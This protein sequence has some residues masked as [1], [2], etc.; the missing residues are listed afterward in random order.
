MAPQ[1]QTVKRK[2]LVLGGIEAVLYERFADHADI[3]HVPR[4]K[5]FRNADIATVDGVIMLTAQLSHTVVRKVKKTA[6]KNGVPC[7]YLSS[8]SATRFKCLLE[9]ICGGSC[10]R[11]HQ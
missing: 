6:C 1:E 4:V 3:T 11:K 10:P 9:E 7:H 5:K 2:Y 8:S